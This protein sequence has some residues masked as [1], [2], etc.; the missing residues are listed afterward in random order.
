MPEGETRIWVEEGL[1][2]WTG[3]VL[4][5]FRNDGKQGSWRLHGLVVQRW[6]A[7][8]RR[9]DRSLLK[10]WDSEHHYESALVPTS[11]LPALTRMMTAVGAIR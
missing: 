3:N 7:E 10:V 9:G 4:E 11:E 1:L 2:V 5:L 8:P 6:E